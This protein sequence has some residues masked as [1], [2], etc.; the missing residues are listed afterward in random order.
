MTE[1]S[2]I[3]VS[4]ND[5]GLTLH[6]KQY[7][8]IEGI[9]DYSLRGELVG[10][11]VF[12]T[13]SVF[14]V[15]RIDDVFSVPR[16]LQLHHNGHRR[17]WISLGRH[18]SAKVML[19]SFDGF[20]LRVRY[21]QGRRWYGTVVYLENP[22]RLYSLGGYEE[23]PRS[24][25]LPWADKAFLL[26]DV[27]PLRGLER[28]MVRHA[29]FYETG[30]IGAEI[31]YSLL[32]ERLGIRGLILNE[33]GKGGPDLHTEDKRLIAESRF[34]I[35]VE[36][37]ML[38]AQISRDLAQMTRRIRHEFRRNCGKDAGYVVIS[39]LDGG[40]IDSLVVEMRSPK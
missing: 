7:P 14:A 8:P 16:F 39:F 10:S 5:G 40:R 36:P 1:Q 24:I 15:V 6:V 13:G 18:K 21:R 30:R 28:M 2:E 23:V 27:R 4:M 26:R 19:L 33:P 12:Q 31:T 37:D 38:K 20:R 9:S 34:L 22:V 29:D 17:A 3:G 25:E 32:T 35:G 11:L